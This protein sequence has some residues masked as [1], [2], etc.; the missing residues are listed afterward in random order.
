MSDQPNDK[1]GK[2]GDAALESERKLRMRGQLLDRAGREMAVVRAEASGWRQ[3]LPGIELK[4]LHLDKAQG[5]QTALWRMA[6]GA[7]IPPHPHGQ[8]EECFLLEGNLEHDGQ[9]YGAGDYM[10]APAGSRHGAITSPDGALMLIRGEQVS[11]R[12]RLLLRASL[13]LG[14]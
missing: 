2:S 11:A 14:R 7:R 5:I 10:V 12:Q 8:D 1:A 9:R 13:A 4:L 6:A 3:F